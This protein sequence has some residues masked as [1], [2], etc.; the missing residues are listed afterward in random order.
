MF[1]DPQKKKKKQTKTNG[2]F[3]PFFPFGHNDEIPEVPAALHKPNQIHPIKPAKL[4]Q[5]ANLHDLGIS[6]ITVITYRYY[7]MTTIATTK[8]LS[9]IIWA[10][11]SFYF[12]AHFLGTI[13][14]ILI[15]FGHNA[16]L[17]I[18]E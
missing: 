4:V 5:M 14:I 13:L 8:A 2:I 15:H 1:L 12:I 9:H 6:C 3:C 18:D 10:S 7:G 17:A 16:W 11:S